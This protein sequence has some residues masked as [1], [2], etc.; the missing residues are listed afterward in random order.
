M[1]QSMYLSIISS[2]FCPMG[3]THLQMSSGERIR[4]KETPDEIL[5]L[6]A[7]NASDAEVKFW[8]ELG[9]KK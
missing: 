4:V 5:V 8:T 6:A 3:W 7:Q 1:I 9:D 2:L